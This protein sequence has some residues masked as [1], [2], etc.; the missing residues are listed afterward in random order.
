MWQREGQAKKHRY[1]QTV[2]GA[3]ACAERQRS[4]AEEMD[5]LSSPL[6]EIVWGPYIAGRKVGPWQTTVLLQD[7]NTEVVVGD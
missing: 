5:W 7:F 4:A 6:P 3:R 2:E 1:Y